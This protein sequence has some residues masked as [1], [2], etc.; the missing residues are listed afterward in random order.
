MTE[1]HILIVEDDE[2][3]RKLLRK[4]LLAEGYSVDSAIEGAQALNLAAKRHPDLVITDIMMPGI[5][6]YEL[7]HRIRQ[8]GQLKEVP[9]IFLSAT[10]VSE[11][12]QQL[13]YALGASRFLVKPVAPAE[14]FQAIEEV[15]D[16]A[17]TGKVPQADSLDRS[18]E[19]REAYQKTLSRKLSKK[20][21]ELQ[22]SEARYQRLL[23][24]L[25]DEYFFFA[26][27]RYGR[28]T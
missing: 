7:C 22:A 8:S 24:G 25:E 19:L 20:L 5:D 9:V 23:E 2:D 1:R 13:A 14:L 17:D 10:F 26:R 6:G 16:G 3:S 28:I 4:Q 15:L 11:E 27:D 21:G 18:P 12:D